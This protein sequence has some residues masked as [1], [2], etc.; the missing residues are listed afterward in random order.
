MIRIDNKIDCCGCM[1][2]VQK[3][4]KQ[5]I[6]M[7]VDKEGFWYPKVDL[8][9]C[10]NCGLCESVCPQINC[11]ERIKILKTFAYKHTNKDIQIHS[12]S[13]GAFTL[14]ADKI[15]ND[16]GVVFGAVFDNN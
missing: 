13:G 7:K 12:S 4:P 1:A 5:S 6:T 9:L 16:G 2:C 14:L 3:C 11:G 10:I 8:S 15:I